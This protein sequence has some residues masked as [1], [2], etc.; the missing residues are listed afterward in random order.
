MINFKIADIGSGFL[1]IEKPSGKS[2]S[3]KLGEIVKAEVMDILPS[4]GVA[5]KIKGDFITAKTEVPMEKGSAAF[6]KV[7]TLP[8]EG[9]ELKLQFM[10]YETDKSEVKSQKSELFFAGTEGKVISKLVQELSDSLAD[11][12]RF[13]ASGEDLGRHT[14]KLQTL[15]SE[16]LK[17]LPSDINSMPKEL[18]I[19]LQ[20]LLQT[21]L[22]IT[23]QS[24]QTRLDTFMNQLP[25]EIKRHPIV[26][27]IIKDLMV[28]DEKLLQSPLKNALQD[29]GVALEAKLRAVVELFQQME[30]L[31]N[32]KSTMVRHESL[33]LPLNKDIPLSGAKQP[34]VNADK[35]LEG[36][37]KSDV[38]EPK[39]TFVQHDAE[40]IKKD[41]KAGL[42][43]LKQLIMDGGM[44]AVKKIQSHE[45]TAV[46]KEITVRAIDGL[47]KDIETFQLLSKT[48]DS[49]YTFLPISW[50]ELRDGE[51]A[52]KRGHSDSK[53]TSYS[54]R[55]NLDLEKF[56]KLKIIVLMYNREFF[57]SF[58]A[59]NPEFQALLSSHTTELQESFT[60]RGLNLKAVNMLD[61][62]DNSLE[63]LERLEPFEKIV[64]IK[65]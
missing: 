17:A 10:G 27:N 54:C 24:I 60:A 62:S 39:Q 64:S 26:E 63:Q 34:H 56:G 28:N 42:L 50:Q 40:S 57:V 23:G 52:F 7:N 30:Q 38:S 47:L 29:T 49:F 9:K 44:D 46:Q 22:K 25:A 20:S 51:I 41:L 59:E 11:T 1:T 45:F 33:T 4:G 6:F 5:L 3:L 55:I 2:I 61:I 19:Q 21:S 13:A 16:L 48:T 37:I 31:D 18:R 53:G 8:A 14:A 43:Q 32:S 58:K 65:A 15:N 36:M 12:K 35:S